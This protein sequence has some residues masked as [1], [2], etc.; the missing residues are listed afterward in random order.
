MHLFSKLYVQLATLL[1]KFNEGHFSTSTI[2]GS[3][4]DIIVMID[5]QW[6]GEHDSKNFCD[7]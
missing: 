7:G 1:T 3:Y 6:Y 2:P 5:R 4:G